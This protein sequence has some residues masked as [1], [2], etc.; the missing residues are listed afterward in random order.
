MPTFGDSCP[1]ATLT[2]LPVGLPQIR[3]FKHDSQ[4]GLSLLAG[5]SDGM[6]NASGDFEQICL[7]CPHPQIELFP[8][9]C[10]KLPQYPQFQM[11]KP[12][13]F[14]LLE[15]SGHII[16][17]IIHLLTSMINKI[18]SH[19]SQRVFIIAME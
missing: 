4:E 9:R 3:L 8:T 7:W 19:C 16:L 13:Q 1:G 11:P 14:I 15:R 12:G 18:L 5:H 17:P 2:D 10:N 6:V